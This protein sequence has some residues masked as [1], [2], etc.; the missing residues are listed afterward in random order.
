[1]PR[2]PV[3]RLGQAPETPGLPSLA[4]SSL[5]ISLEGLGVGV[6]NLRHDVALSPRF[7]DAARAQMARLI[8]RHGEVEGLLASEAPPVTS[9]PSWMRPQALAG[10]K[11]EPNDW[12][13]MLAQLHLAALKRSKREEKISLD[14]L[15]RL[16]VVKFLRGE[17]NLQFAQV[18][19]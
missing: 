13:S 11:S 19:H 6:D 1:M 7:L 9:V 2:L 3:F 4:E 14:Q 5:P 18:L 17:M 10:A 15:A 8:V 12:K 16:A